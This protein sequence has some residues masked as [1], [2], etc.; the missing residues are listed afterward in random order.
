MIYHTDKAEL[1]A[2]LRRVLSN[3]DCEQEVVENTP[4]RFVSALDELLSG[5]EENDL[6]AIQFDHSSLDSLVICKDIEF[7]SL[8][9]HHLLPFHGVVNIGYIP[10]GKVIGLSKLPRVV[11]HFA[12]RLQIQ[13]HFTS[14]IASYLEG[15][16]NP[17]GV[18]VAVEAEHMCVR[19]RGIKNQG[20]TMVTS[21]IR[22]EFRS[23]PETRAEFMQLIK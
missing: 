15:Q 4:K 14:Q 2:N 19:M 12:R 18:A 11:N 7:Y 21:E 20:A 8:C 23:E 1:I 10:N 6:A 13:E 5:Y 16:L 17:R 22:G 3:L 9:E